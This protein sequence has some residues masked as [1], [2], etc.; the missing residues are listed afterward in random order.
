MTTRRSWVVNLGVLDVARSVLV[1]GVIA[2]AVVSVTDARAD[3]SAH[4]GVKMST[5]GGVTESSPDDVSY[6]I[7]RSIAGD[8][9]ETGYQFDA[10]VL[11]DSLIAGLGGEASKFSDAD[12]QKIMMGFNQTITKKRQEMMKVAG[13]KNEK[14][15]KEFL[16]KNASA[17]GVKALPSGLQY[18][19][20][21]DGTGESPKPTDT[22]VAHYRGALLDGTEF[23]SSFKRGQPAEFPLQGVIKGWQ[24]ALVLMKPGAKWELVIP[25]DLA[26]GDNGAGP[27]IGPKATLKFDVEL[28]SVK[29]KK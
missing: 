22:V 16:A 13:E 2:A 27:K 6:V 21:K 4:G 10:K 11:A 28:I 17:P 25:P 1:G 18:K 5:E 24:E 26:Y 15:G 19:V 3:D 9:R 23:D 7:G 14:E 20:V 29:A 12:S 8:L